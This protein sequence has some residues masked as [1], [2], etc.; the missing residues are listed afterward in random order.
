[1]KRFTGKWAAAVL[2]AALLILALSGAAAEQM[3]K[4]TVMR[5]VCGADLERDHG[6]ESASMADILASRYN[7]EE[8]NVIALLGGT[9]RWAGNRFDPGVLNVVSVSGR[10]PGKVDEMPLGAMSDP[11]TLTAF[12]R[13]C[14]ENY[15]AEHYILVICDH[16]GGPLNGCCVDFLF[17]R[18][19]L[20]VEALSKALADSP[21][22]E[23]GLDTIAFDCCLMGSLEIGNCLVPYAKYMVATE[24]VMYG[25]NQDWLAG[26][27]ND[28]S[29]LETARRIA[30]ST[31]IRNRDAIAAQKAPQLNSVAVIDLEKVPEVTAAMD[32]YFAQRPALDEESF[33][34]VSRQRRDAVTFGVT[35]S[36]GIS[37]P[38]LVDVGSLVTEL[39]AETPEGA[40]LL[41]TI[42]NAVLSEGTLADNCLGMTVYHPY[43][44][45]KNAE[46]GMET[47]A[48][49]HFAPAYV[50]YVI[51]Y[52]SIMT[53]K[54][55]ASWAGLL[56]GRPEA[57]KDNRTLFTL[58]LS[59]EQAAHFADAKMKIFRKEGA[60]GYAFAAVQNRT[61]WA[62][63]KVT[64]EFNG[65]SLFA[66][67]EE[68]AP[69]TEALNYQ[70]AANGMLLIPAELT[71]PGEDGEAPAIHR[72]LIYG[73]LNEKTKAVTPAG[74]AVWDESTACWTGSY[75]TSF[76]DY[77]KM[78]VRHESRKES[79][80]ENGVLLPFDQWEK[81]S[82][83][84]RQWEL[85]IGENWSFRMLDVMDH[86]EEL[87]ASF[88]VQDSQ[89]NLYASELYRIR[90]GVVSADTLITE[91][92]D[93][94]LVLLENLSLK[95]PDQI[96]LSAGVT[97]LTE[98][99]AI[100]RL[101]H[102]TVNGRALE[103]LN[104]EVYGN[105]ENWGL[106]QGE[107]QVLSLTIPAEA[108]AEEGEISSLT[109]DLILKNAADETE[110]LGTVP[111]TVTTRL[112][113]PE[114]M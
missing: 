89:G 36:G 32:R 44:N 81:A 46:G 47:Y 35:E 83:A 25:M 39:G 16:G 37:Q 58:D 30:N 29:E 31:Y 21:F 65:M 63:R 86:A 42:R 93:A 107:T 2:I 24:D 3:K 10:R 53:G 59:G 43:A 41:E 75:G 96:V 18:S 60:E 99:E 52:T 73:E 19:M 50:D 112:K 40:A 108:A 57:Q 77:S 49:L 106:L 110:I 33:T 71:L 8:I 15:P 111:V 66:V 78:T 104:A 55:L 5:Y 6:Q 13:Y 45:R 23:R 7:T 62:E 26:L 91:Y 95:I 28:A 105:G 69:L 76:A 12:L 51:T 98:T 97:N 80:D 38:D 22:A 74:V 92:N 17:N 56:T 70:I 64:G 67:D 34:A 1:M 100:I 82:E 9:P 79:R 84:D 61:D 4:Y 48:G 27:E 68:G 14:R 85:A 72:A 114:T 90:A 88:E 94:E 109:F 102:L 11:A 103:D 20:S 87:Y 113:L 54:P 101:D